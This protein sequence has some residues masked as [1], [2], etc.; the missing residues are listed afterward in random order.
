M[1]V[2]FGVRGHDRSSNR[3]SQR[4]LKSIRGHAQFV[5][6]TYYINEELRFF[7][8]VGVALQDHRRACLAVISYRVRCWLTRFSWPSQVAGFP[9][10][11]WCGYPD[12]SRAARAVSAQAARSCERHRPRLAMPP[13]HP[14]R[15]AVM[16]R[17]ALSASRVIQDWTYFCSNTARNARAPIRLHRVVAGRAA[18]FRSRHDKDVGDR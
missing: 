5:H 4:S 15:A 2:G 14:E 16:P 6:K 17:A 1:V 13:L 12:L 18:S 7:Y 9:G 8:Y 3:R 11:E 10:A